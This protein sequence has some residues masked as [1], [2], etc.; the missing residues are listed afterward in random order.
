MEITQ[1]E[2]TRFKNML[3]AINT[4]A[5]DDMMDWLESKGGI[6]NVS[7]QEMSSYGYALATKY[8]EASASLSAQMYDEVATASGMTLP[9]AEV[10]DTVSYNEIA[11]AITKVAAQTQN[12]QRVS[13]VVGRY[14][15]RTGA[16][17]MLKNAE[18]DGA[19]FAWVPAGDSCAFCITLASRGW[20]YISKKSFKNGHAE[21]IHSNCDCTYAVRFDKNT[22]VAG[23]DPDKYL[24]MYQNAE[25]DTW[26]EKVNSMRRAQ[27]QEPESH[28][29]ILAQKRNA[30]EERNRKLNYGASEKF[31]KGT[32][33][34]KASP[35]NKYSENNIYVADNLKLKNSE[36]RYVNKRITEAKNILGIGEDCNIPVVIV[37]D[38]DN[39]ASYNPRTNILYVSSRMTNAQKVTSLQKTYAAS[40][41]QNSTAVH[42]LIHWKDAEDYRKN[43]GIIASAEPNSEYTIYQRDMALKKLIEEGVDIADDKE[44]LKIS[45]YAYKKSIENDFEE[46]YT[47]YRT[48]KVLR[49]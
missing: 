47:E 20:Q 6:A 39:L 10:A 23:Y 16:D 30:Y 8:G 14:T 29:K 11:K 7:F 4:R 48:N 21:H 1:A 41:N 33:T 37:E 45:E 28:K 26:Q 12:A 3:S 18:R 34:I 5:V 43:I 46:I 25:G 49:R 32:Q 17:T 35:V 24:E 2:W 40:D 27:Y 31:V 44:L 42:E 38:K 36:I 13:D 9:A 22:N 15:K 19:Q